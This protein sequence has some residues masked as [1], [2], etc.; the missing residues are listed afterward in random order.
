MDTQASSSS[1]LL[2]PAFTKGK[3]QLSA[4]EVEVSHKIASVRIHIERVI[5]L[6]RNRYTILKGILPLRLLKSIK[7]EKSSSIIA[8]CDKI[9]VVCSALTNLNGSIVF[10]KNRNT[11][12]HSEDVNPFI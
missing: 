12:G 7:D 3:T 9:V 1:E 10:D 6:L 8:N 5:G 2:I 11:P 4:K